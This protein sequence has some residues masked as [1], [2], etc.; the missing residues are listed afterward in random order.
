[1][2]CV[3]YWIE[4]KWREEGST[5]IV[6]CAIYDLCWEVYCHIL[7][8]AGSTCRI[9]EYRIIGLNNEWIT[10]GLHFDLVLAAIDEDYWQNDVINF[11]STQWIEVD[12]SIG[13]CHIGK[14]G[15]EHKWAAWWNTKVYSWDDIAPFIQI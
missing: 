7:Y 12:Y 2:N 4:I 5:Y 8:I 3:A 15:I 11:G 9:K 13:W 6:A 14:R 10:D 1:M